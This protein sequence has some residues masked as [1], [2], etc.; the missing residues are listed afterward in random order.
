HWT[1]D[2]REGGGRIVGEGCHFVDLMQFWTGAH[3]TRVHAE[4][5]AARDEQVTDED[6]V[7]VTLRF[8]DGS[9]G[10]LAYVAEGDR[11][12]PKERAELFGGGLAFVL[13]DFRRATLHRG[14]REEALKLRAQDKGQAG[15]ARAVCALVRAGGPL[16][17]PLEDLANTSRA[18]F[19]IRESLRAGRPLDV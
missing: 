2:P 7:V 3:V 12:L 19:R 8:A 13:E 4:A 10:V 18:T 14:G 5:V 9:N 16:L 17:T 1:Q 6:N 15:Q 11:S